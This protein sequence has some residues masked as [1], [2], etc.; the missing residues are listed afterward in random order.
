MSS[1][2]PLTRF[3]IHSHNDCGLAV[4]NSILAVEEGVEMVQ[5]TINGYGERSGN[6]NLCSIIP[7]LKLKMGLDCISDAQLSKLSEVS[8]Y[9]SELANL[10]PMAR[11]PY[12]GSSAFAHKGASMSA[13]F[14]RM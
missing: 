8:H 11:Q 7:A 9:V 2:T 10:S 14:E 6:A 12:V 4:A 5:G 13:P 3:G 1:E